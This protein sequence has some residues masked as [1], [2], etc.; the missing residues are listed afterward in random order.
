MTKLKAD[1]GNFYYGARYYD[2]HISIW[3]SVDPMS[4]QRPG[5]TPYNF[6]SNNPIMRTDPTGMLDDWYENKLGEIVWYDRVD[7]SFTDESGSNWENVG[8]TL[9]DVKQHLNVPEINE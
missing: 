4:D 6:V 2:P 7:E 5:L 9:D 3:L 8:E 1:T